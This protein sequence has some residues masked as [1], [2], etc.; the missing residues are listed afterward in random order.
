[1]RNIRILA[2]AA[3]VGMVTAC[4]DSGTSSTTDAGLEATTTA[5]AGTTATTESTETTA[6]TTAPSAVGTFVDGVLQPLEDGFPNGPLTLMVIDE[7]GSSDSLFATELSAIASAMSPV[8]V[9]V[10]HR[11]DFTNFGTWE[12]I[13]FVRND[14][15]GAEGYIAFMISLQGSTMDTITIPPEDLGGGLDDLN[16]VMTAESVPYAMY[17]RN[18]PAPEWGTMTEMVEFAQANP[19]TVNYISP[20]P[21]GAQDAAFKYYQQQLDFTV[22]ET[23][24]PGTLERALV[25]A[26]GEGDITLAPPEVVLPHW[27]AGKVEVI[28]ITGSEAPEPWSEVPTSADLGIASDPYGLTRGIA[29]SPTAPPEHKEW[30][31]T[32]FTAAIEDPVYQEQ[33]ASVPGLRID[34]RSSDEAR[35]QIQD[36]YDFT[37]PIF[38]ELGMT[39]QDQQ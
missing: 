20:G 14:E 6:G 30:L 29:V 3:V 33:R 22:N 34:V 1:M 17:R 19:N 5:P 8:E 9:V 21:G 12:G 10:E 24:V 7:V 39:W 18:D 37:L 11:T 26:A 15:R 32:L 23:V 27:E 35:E 13:E 38:E 36:I 16:I 2:V 25:V 4:A 28:M 31:E